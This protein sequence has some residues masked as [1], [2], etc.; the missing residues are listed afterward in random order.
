MTRNFVQDES[1]GPGHFQ[2]ADDIVSAP[3]AGG[4]AAYPWLI[5][6]HP[7]PLPMGEG[8]A[9]TTGTPGLPLPWGE[10]WGEGR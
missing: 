3:A 9:R 7:V 8:D 1:G 6:P 10:G 5:A 4:D 2:D